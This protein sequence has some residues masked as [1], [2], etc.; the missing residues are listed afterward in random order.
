[1]FTVMIS[2]LHQASQ[3]IELNLKTKPSQLQH[4]KEY[5]VM[6][7]SYYHRIAMFMLEMNIQSPACDKCY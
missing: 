6:L 4:L 7:K 2:L 5:K 3:K 1:M